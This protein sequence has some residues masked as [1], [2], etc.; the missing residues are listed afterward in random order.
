M[1]ASEVKLKLIGFANGLIDTYFSGAS[2]TEKMINST[3][4][5]IIKQNHC[6]DCVLYVNERKQKLSFS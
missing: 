6:A 5:I 4:K 3:L 2:V 1:K